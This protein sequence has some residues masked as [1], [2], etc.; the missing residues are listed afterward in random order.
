MHR[1]SV[2]LHQGRFEEALELTQEAVRKSP[3]PW[4]WSTLAHCHLRLHRVAE[5]E[6]VVERMGRE[7][8]DYP[9]VHAL[10][11]IGA[12]LRG[13][14][15]RAREGIERAAHSPRTFGHYHHAQYGV[16]CAYAALRDPDSAVEWLGEAAHNGYPCHPF[17]AVDPLLDPLRD[18]AGFGRLMDELATQ[19]DGYRRLYEEIRAGA[20]DPGVG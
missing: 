18:H 16:A 11:A 12:A 3:T 19:C 9:E 7:S 1:G 10:T 17:F 6:H 8:P 14:S 2:R 20:R 15:V 4:S 5:A 13:D